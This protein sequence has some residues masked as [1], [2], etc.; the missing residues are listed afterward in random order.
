[1]TTL[2][3]DGYTISV[4]GVEIFV[5][6][7]TVDEA[8]KTAVKCRIDAIDDSH[9]GENPIEMPLEIEAKLVGVSFNTY[10]CR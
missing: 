7:D 6:A 3:K 10:E 1:M 5:S 8:I 4:N 2:T 9:Y